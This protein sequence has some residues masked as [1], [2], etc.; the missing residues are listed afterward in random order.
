MANQEPTSTPY[1]DPTAKRD[2]QHRAALD[3]GRAREHLP[4]ELVVELT[5][6]RYSEE[7]RKSRRWLIGTGL[8]VFGAAATI[9]GVLV[10]VAFDGN[11]GNKFDDAFL[12]ENKASFLDFQKANDIKELGIGERLLVEIVGRQERLFLLGVPTD[13]LYQIDVEAETRGLDPTLS[14]FDDSLRVQLASND[15]WGDG[16]DSRVLVGLVADHR[17]RIIVRELT[18]ADG[19]VFVSL[20]PAGEVVPVQ[21]AAEQVQPIRS[22]LG[23]L[24]LGRR[25]EFSLGANETREFT[26]GVD[27]TGFYQIDLQ[28]EGESLDPIMFL[29]LVD[30][31]SIARESLASDDD[32]GGQLSSRLIQRLEGEAIYLVRAGEFLGQ[33]GRFQLSMARADSV[34][35]EVGGEQTEDFG[36][37]EQR[38]FGLRGG[39]ASCY[40]IEVVLVEGL[41][42]PY[43][44]LLDGEAREL[45][46]DDDGGSAL[47]ARI[48][49]RLDQGVLYWLRVRENGLGSGTFGL[50]FAQENENVC[51][52]EGVDWEPEKASDAG[53]GFGAR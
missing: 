16:L 4:L 47:D 53:S 28:A 23:S 41:G 14:L 18:G 22:Q 32:G 34:E 39:E 2:L 8:A 10:N 9:S 33:P 40:R 12:E 43:V 37:R 45:A 1:N 52:G 31:G 6:A 19:S 27:A 30:D 7:K 5:H 49:V 48:R 25:E 46:V 20:R 3:L 50:S 44:V 42:D 15:D 29:D 38:I 21:S 13:G 11:L 26:V 17:Y 36:R 35:F 51:V 24:E